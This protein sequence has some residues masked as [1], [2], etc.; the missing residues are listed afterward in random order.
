MHVKKTRFILKIKEKYLYN[1]F[2]P[3]INTHYP[4]NLGRATS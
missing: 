4:N 3:K 1:D 2:A